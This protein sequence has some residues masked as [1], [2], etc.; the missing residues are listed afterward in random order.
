MCGIAGILRF[1]G[2]E[3]APAE[4][5]AMTDALVHRGPDDEGFYYG[6]GVGLGMRRLSIIDL[7]TG[8][9]PIRNEDGT[10]WLVFNGEIYNFAEL[11]RELL[12]QGHQFRTATDTEVIVHLYEDLGSRCVDRLRGMFAFAL[13]DERRRTLLL[14]RDR[15]GIKPLYYSHHGGR[16]AFAS[17]LKALLELA[18]QPRELDW[19]AVS[20]L[21]TFST[22]PGERSIVDGVAKLPPG[23]LL[24]ASAGGA[25]ATR[26][27][28][29][30]EF[31]PNHRRSER[32]WIEML[33]GT[34]EESVRLHR[35][36]DVPLGAF[37]SGGIDSSAVVAAMAKGG[38]EPVHTFSIGFHEADFN[39]LDAARLVSQA[40]ATR[41][42]EEVLGPEVLPALDDLAWYLDEPFGD[43][44]AI[45]T[46]MVSRLAGREVTVVLT[47]DGGDEVFAGYDRYVVER[48]ERWNRFLPAP[49]RRLLGAVGEALPEGATGRELLRHTA[50]VGLDRTLDAGLL[51]KAD[52]RRRLFRPDVQARMAGYDPAESAR[53]C[54][55]SGDDHWLSTMQRLDFETYL[56]LDILTKVDRMSMAHSVETRV[57]LLD[58]VL[59]ELAATLPPA[60]RLGRD[61]TKIAFKRALA[62]WLP[63]PILQRPKR[64]FAIPLGRWFRDGLAPFVRELLLGPRSRQREIF[65]GDYIERLL[66]LHGAGRPLDLQLWTLVS[67]E[68]WCRTFLDRRPVALRSRPPRRP[69]LLAGGRG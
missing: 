66:R 49:A 69:Q 24:T 56:P 22:T 5:Q 65:A 35:V 41:H 20:H 7:A 4:L 19:A 16:L 36:S 18:D 67:F 61:G 33:R 2:G 48:R 34:L 21:F 62:G 10:V 68:L 46:Y 40:F 31:A 11:R 9:Q 6:S 52:Q 23:H 57:P 3:V 55:A 37:L 50:L 15:V 39:E 42:R 59:V 30:I 13:W 17:E 12:A 51:F 53:R 38:T 32:Q 26:R 28:W 44:S 60:L 27:Y 8:H 63:E 14:A 54:L 64:G 29:Q 25:L 47:G 58:H 1:D 43:S 45:P